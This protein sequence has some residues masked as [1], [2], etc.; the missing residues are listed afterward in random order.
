M[1]A[2]T[3]LG[4][5]AVVLLYCGY[6]MSDYLVVFFRGDAFPG[7]RLSLLVGGNLIGRLVLGIGILLYI[8]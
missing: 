5:C 7:A 8:G 4:L 3:A 2:L 6:A 1:K